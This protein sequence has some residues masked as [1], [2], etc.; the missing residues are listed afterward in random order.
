MSTHSTSHL[1]GGLRGILRAVMIEVIKYPEPGYQGLYGF[2]VSRFRVSGLC[3]RLTLTRAG[4]PGA[5][6]YPIFAW[7]CMVLINPIITVRMTVPITIL[8]HLRGL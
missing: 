2:E 4:Q 8:G 5:N 6:V 7:R 1:L 3:I